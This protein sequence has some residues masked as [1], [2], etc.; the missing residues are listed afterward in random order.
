MDFS[1][2]SQQ[3]AVGMQAWAAGLWGNF[4]LD[5]ALRLLVVY[6]FFIWG[7]LV[8]WVARDV[9]NRSSSLL[10]QALCVLLVLAL[11]PLGVFI[12]LLI[13]PQRT[14][15]EKFYESEL[16]PRQPGDACPGCGAGVRDEWKFCPSCDHVLREACGGCGALVETAWDFCPSCGKKREE[17]KED[18]K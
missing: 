18:K 12:Y 3:A 17:K 5:L 7:S 8:V 2:F 13:R 1:A 6:L 15:F 16:A 11:S 4:S 10:F 9:T 14:A